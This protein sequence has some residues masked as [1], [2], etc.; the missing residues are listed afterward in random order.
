MGVANAEA[1]VAAR[2][3]AAG[4]G[5]AL[6]EGAASV[7]GV[8]LVAVRLASEVTAFDAAEAV[9]AALDDVPAVGPLMPVEA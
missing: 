1:G 8:R 7:E 5:L 6:L 2:L 9:D 3:V 4:S